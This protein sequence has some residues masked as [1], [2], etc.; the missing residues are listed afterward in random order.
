M[1]FRPI[2]AIVS[3]SIKLGGG[4][5]VAARHEDV[6]KLVEQSEQVWARDVLVEHDLLQVVLPIEVWTQP[7]TP[8]HYV[9]PCN[10]IHSTGT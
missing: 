5:L 7:E 2:L 8:H 10:Y 6:F 4:V 3:S 9:L 1:T